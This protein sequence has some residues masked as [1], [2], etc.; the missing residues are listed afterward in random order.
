[1][2]KWEYER[3]DLNNL[4]RTETDIDVLNGAGAQGWELVSINSCNI[5]I[6]KRAV[7]APAPTR[8][9]KSSAA[10]APAASAPAAPRSK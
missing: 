1:M 2:T 10:A 9:T 7:A 6:L 8:A 5:A 3:I 4:G